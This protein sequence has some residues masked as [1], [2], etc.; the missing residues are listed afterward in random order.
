[1]SPLTTQ[2]LRRIARGEAPLSLWPLALFCAVATLWGLVH[3]SVRLQLIAVGY[4]ISR[5]TQ[6]QHDLT[7]LT[8]RLSLELRTRMDLGTVEKLARERLGMVPIDPQRVRS[9]ALP[10]QGEAR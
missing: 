1:M 9:L 10:A 5:Q 4:E 2:A 3:V 6:L 7:E 8:Q